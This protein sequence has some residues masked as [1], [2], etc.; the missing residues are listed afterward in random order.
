MAAGALAIFLTAGVFGVAIAWLRGNS[1]TRRR[2]TRHARH[3]T[4]AEDNARPERVW[5]FAILATVAEVSS[6]YIAVAVRPRWW[7]ALC[8]Y[9]CVLAGLWWL[10]VAVNG[11]RQQREMR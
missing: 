3:T 5:F 2:W 10:A 4:D 1:E 9:D 8:C 6:V 7:A 11:H